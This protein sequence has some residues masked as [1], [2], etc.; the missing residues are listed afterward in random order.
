MMGQLFCFLGLVIRLEIKQIL[1]SLIWG[2]WTSAWV[3]SGSLLEMQM[4]G[5]RPTPAEAESVCEDPPGGFQ[6]TSNRGSSGW[7]EAS[8]T[9]GQLPH[10]LLP[11]FLW[12]YFRGRGSGNV[13]GIKHTCSGWFLIPPLL[14]K[15]TD[16][17]PLVC[18][19]Q[20]LT[21]ASEVSI[22][23]LATHLRP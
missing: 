14:I 8:S 10:L 7:V 12:E 20:W 5:S 6:C 19:L 17:V 15:R 16:T 2:L 11:G 9:A 4:P 13:W 22:E 3:S 23:T 1:C 21:K 18:S